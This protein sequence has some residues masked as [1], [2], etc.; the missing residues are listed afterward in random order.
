LGVGNAA[1]PKILS[2]RPI[3]LEQLPESD[4]ERLNAPCLRVIADG[5]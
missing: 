1:Y 2:N 4:V 5:V 3:E